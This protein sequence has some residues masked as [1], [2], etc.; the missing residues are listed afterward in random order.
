LPDAAGVTQLPPSKAFPDGANPEE[1]RPYHWE[2]QPLFE[3]TAIEALTS[4]VLGVYQDDYLFLVLRD[5]I[6]VMRD[7]AAAQLKV[8]D[9]IEQW[10][11]DDKRQTQYLSG[12]YIQS[13]YDVNDSRLQ[14]LSATDA[15]IQALRDETSEAQQA[16]IYEFLKVRRDHK[17]PGIFGPDQHWRRAAE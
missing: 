8:A 9:W 15:D 2:E 5:D 13:L 14:A 7:L 11:A 4:K 16:S 12:A 17:D 6:G 1:K 3:G 10:S